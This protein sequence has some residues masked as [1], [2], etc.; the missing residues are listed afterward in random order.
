M[1]C[2]A[3]LLVLT[4][5]GCSPA[6][7]N[8]PT[9]SPASTQPVLALLSEPAADTRLLGRLHTVGDMG[10]LA[11]IAEVKIDRDLNAD[12][13]EK[14][15]AACVTPKNLEQLLTAG[16]PLAPGDKLIDEWSYAPWC[17]ATFVAAGRKWS[18]ALYLGGLG[19]IADDA[20]RKGAFRFD[21][22]RGDGS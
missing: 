15:G 12:W 19:V 4:L 7:D 17:R 16:K 13:A 1:R 20:G 5:T 8:A 18:V 11:P 21:V 9:T 22:P 14:N 2:F 6:A 10:R 3:L